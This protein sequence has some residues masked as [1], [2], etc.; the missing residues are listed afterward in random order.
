MV[1]TLIFFCVVNAQPVRLSIMPPH[2]INLF[3]A[4]VGF[5]GIKDLS[6]DSV[7]LCI[8]ALGTLANRFRWVDD[9]TPV[10]DAQWND[11]DYKVSLALDEIMGGLIG[12][13]LP[14]IFETIPSLSL[15]PCDGGLYERSDYPQL[16]DVLDLQFIENS[17]QF[18]TPDLRRR[19]VVGSG[20][21]WSLGDTGGA[22]GV[23]L[24]VAQLPPHNHS[25]DQYTFGI[26]IE[27]VGVPDP[28]GVGQPAL[29]NLTS[30]TG[31][32]D[33]HENMPPYFVVDWFV[34]AR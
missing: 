26:D 2:D 7:A 1:K 11:I 23:A 10:S 21:G 19:V 32:G 18:R 12:A 31:S 22:E 3:N 13:L 8:M 27:S 9:K 15:L 4:S 20:S 30:D 29:P 34:I 24:S 16:Y 33:E 25:Y 6:P 17:T 14:A 28:T 5:G